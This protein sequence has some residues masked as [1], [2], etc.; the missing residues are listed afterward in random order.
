[1]SKK[2]V[3]VG[4]SG[5]VDSS[6]SALLLKEQGY[7]VHGIFMVNW[8]DEDDVDYCSH[9]ED[10][11]FVK[12]VCG[13]H[14]IPYTKVNFAEQ[15]WQKVFDYFLQEYQSGRTPNPDILCNKEIKFKAFYDYA[16]QQGADFLATGHYAQLQTYGTETKMLK[17][18]DPNKD[19]TYFL[20]A[21]NK[22]VLPN[23][24]FPCGHL[25]KSKVREI[26]S[27]HRLINANRK[28]ST[29]ICFIGE[30]KFKTFLSEYLPAQPGKIKTLDGMTV[31]HHDGLMFYTLGQRKGLKI[32]GIKN[33]PEKPWFIVAK[34]LKTNTLLVTQ[35]DDHEMN[36]SHTVYVKDMNW[37]IDTAKINLV[38][39]QCHAKAR[40]RQS[41]QACKITNIQD[42]LLT[43]SFDVPQRAVT[44]GQSLV[45]YQDNICL[46]GGI[47]ESTDS[48]GGLI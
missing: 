13:Q 43:I 45:L 11:S 25:L 30:R 46:G 1:M 35:D 16:T 32:G 41:D 22:N 24:L 18:L 19:Q 47:I 2:S 6:V 48:A 15:Y 17:G 38:N 10:L 4:L 29:G 20:H 7:D 40:Y 12:N 3:I 28:D 8:T 36:L 39:L 26:A 5:G 42:D 37:L 9:Y 21:I 31:G 14:N 23:I 33:H 44:P 27:D 34:D